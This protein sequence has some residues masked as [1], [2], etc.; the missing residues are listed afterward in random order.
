MIKPDGPGKNA[1][2]GEAKQSYSVEEVAEML[3]VDPESVRIWLNKGL[4]KGR[5]E[6]GEWRI[7]VSV[8]M[9]LLIP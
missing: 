9:K 8:L 6:G 3:R 4:I 2:R 1:G 5:M 7:P